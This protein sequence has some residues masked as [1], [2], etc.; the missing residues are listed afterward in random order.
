MVPQ[1]DVNKESVLW[2][3][4]MLLYGLN[5]AMRKFWLKVKEV[6]SEIG[7]QR[8]KGVKAFYYKM[9]DRGK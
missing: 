3:L 2:K 5:D 8:L 1:K 9:D 7:L 6:F 4:K